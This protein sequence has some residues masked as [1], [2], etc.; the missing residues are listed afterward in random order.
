MNSFINMDDYTS[1]FEINWALSEE[2]SFKQNG[3]F[4]WFDVGLCYFG[5]ALFFLL[6]RHLVHNTPWFESLSNN[7]PNDKFIVFAW[8]IIKWAML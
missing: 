7:E 1:T 2:S 3:I 5:F 4:F 8:Y 6:V